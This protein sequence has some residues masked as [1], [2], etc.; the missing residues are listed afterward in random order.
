[1]LEQAIYIDYW[2][3]LFH[4]QNTFS[5]PFYP[6]GDG[7]CFFTDASLR[8]RVELSGADCDPV[9]KVV[10]DGKYVYTSCRDSYVRK[11]AVPNTQS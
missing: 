4:K 3:I 6:P 2:S 8:T 10:S 1:M 9:Y 11:Y 7:S 5:S